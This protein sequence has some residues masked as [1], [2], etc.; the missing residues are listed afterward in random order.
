MYFRSDTQVQDKIN[1]KKYSMSSYLAHLHECAFRGVLKRP[2][3]FQLDLN[4]SRQMWV[5]DQRWVVL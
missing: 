5:A 1:L 3:R 2:G 4:Y